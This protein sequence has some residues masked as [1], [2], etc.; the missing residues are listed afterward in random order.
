MGLVHALAVKCSY[1]KEHHGGGGEIRTHERLPVAG[2]QDRCLKPLGHTSVTRSAARAC[3]R[4]P[5]KAPRQIWNNTHRDS[6]FSGALRLI[7]P[8][9]DSVN[10][11]AVWY[12]ATPSAAAIQIEGRCAFWHGV[13]VVE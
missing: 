11:D 5:P 12:Y 10:R 7:K 1:G 4:K 8:M 3:R 9:R 2:F 13:Q 6:R